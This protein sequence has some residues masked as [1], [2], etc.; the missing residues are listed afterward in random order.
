MDTKIKKGC[1]MLR[2]G[3]VAAFAVRALEIYLRKRVSRASAALAY[4]LMLSVFPMLI[5]LYE[6]LGS[7]FPTAEDIAALIGGVLPEG[8]LQT[9]Y[10]YIGYISV[11]SSRAMLWGALIAMATSSAAAFRTLHG[12]IG[13]IMGTARFRGLFSL[14]F[15]FAFSLLFLAAIY[16][17]VIVM[18][19]GTWFVRTVGRYISF[20][21][22]GESWRWLR[23]L[24]LFCLLMVIVYA[25]YRLTQPTGSGESIVPGAVFAAGT[26]VA[27]S[28]VFSYFI[29]M[30][31]RYPL[32]YGS[33]A[34]V[35][36]LLLWLYVCGNVLF[37][38]SIINAVLN[39]KD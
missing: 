29:G 23:F 25:L 35:V 14:I 30:S 37:I 17:A 19:T 33:L 6:M 16:F 34:S 3:S 26:L 10:D 1:S 15:S 5:C 7:L 20:I 27:V 36:I 11:N 39:E 32:V 12:M 21:N 9:I 13:E 18:I 28:I 24:L 31:A 4:F 22:F 38:G 8:M 2:K